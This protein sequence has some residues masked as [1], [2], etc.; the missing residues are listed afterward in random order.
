MTR[1][2]LT[3]WWGD[4]PTPSRRTL[5]VAAVL[6]LLAGVG[7]AAAVLSFAAIRDLGTRCGFDPA[8][9]W[10]LPVTVD[11]GAAAGA[12]VWLARRVAP[13]DARTFAQWLC[14][15][16]LGLSVA[17]NG[18][19]HYLS[20]DALTAP[21]ALIVV[22]SAVA[23][24]TLG[25]VVHLVVLTLRTADAPADAPAD[26]HWP[27]AAQW[28]RPARTEPDPLAGDR[29][30]AQPAARAPATASSEDGYSLDLRARAA[31]CGL[32]LEPPA[33]GESKPARRA[34]L[35]RERARVRR[36]AAAPA[37]GRDDEPVETEEFLARYYSPE[38]VGRGE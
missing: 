8:L 3:P 17:A 22:V 30:A 7:A 11:A 16:L 37:S 20:A 19:D 15:T 29:T 27:P 28:P 33:P 5:A 6:V 21:L 32:T 31:R 10:L 38:L 18:V 13:A 4:V 35:S 36:A 9:A 12:I 2:I 23:P 25:A 24:A 14:L 26:V 34:R 1:D